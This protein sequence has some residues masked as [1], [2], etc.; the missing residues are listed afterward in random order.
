EEEGVLFGARTLDMYMAG[1]VFSMSA[2]SFFQTNTSQGNQLVQVVQSACQLQDDQ[3]EVVLDLFCGA[4]LLGLSVAHRSREVHGVEL[5]AD[6]VRDA[7]VNAERNGLSNCHFHQ[8]LRTGLRFVPSSGVVQPAAAPGSSEGRVCV[9]SDERWQQRQVAR[10]GACVCSPMRDGSSAR[11]LGGA[12]VCALRCEMAAETMT[13]ADGAMQ[14]DLG[15]LAAD[16]GSIVP[17]PDVCIVD[18]ARAGLPR[19]LT[20]FL[21]KTLPPRLVYVSCN[22]ATQVSS[23]AASSSPSALP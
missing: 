22:P 19:A 3:S 21:S 5:V 12:R 17:Q 1:L 9:L 14:G 10:R 16:L 20:R 4:G 18:P 15:K 13:G 7:R 6:A 11:W 2:K 8:A 23:R